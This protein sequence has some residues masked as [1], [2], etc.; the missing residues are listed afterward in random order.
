MVLLLS[1]CL[2]VHVLPLIHAII[3]RYLFLTLR[4]GYAIVEKEG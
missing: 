3:L 2:L 4:W 1:P